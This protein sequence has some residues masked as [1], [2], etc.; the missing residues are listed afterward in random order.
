MAYILWVSGA[1]ITILGIIASLLYSDHKGLAIL[2]VFIIIAIFAAVGCYYWYS[3]VRTIPEGTKELAEKQHGNLKDDQKKLGGFHAQVTARGFTLKKAGETKFSIGSGSI[4]FGNMK[5]NLETPIYS[6]IDKTGDGWWQYLYILL[7]THS[8]KLSRENLLIL[9]E[10]PTYRE[11][12]SAWFLRGDGKTI[13]IGILPTKETYNDENSMTGIEIRPFKIINNNMI[14]K[15]GGINILYTTVAPTKFVR[16]ATDMPRFGSIKIFVKVDIFS[17]GL[18]DGT[19]EFQNEIGSGICITDE[20]QSIYY[21]G[22][23]E[24][25]GFEISITGFELP[26]GLPQ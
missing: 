3:K 9:Q 11:D 7:P 22:T 2:L 15:D 25:I 10:A 4:V 13:C 18:L 14:F 16:T 26:K 24:D 21:R 20:S 12:L 1:I 8:G 23:E 5:Y 6:E 17:S 19:V